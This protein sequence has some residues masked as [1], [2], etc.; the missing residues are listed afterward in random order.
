MCNSLEIKVSD[1]VEILPVRYV[2]LETQLFKVTLFYMRQ[3]DIKRQERDSNPIMSLPA[4]PYPRILQLVKG[5][6]SSCSQ[7]KAAGIE[8][9]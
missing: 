6:A 3:I 1:F 5:V 7:H 4:A 9:R 8:H 2:D